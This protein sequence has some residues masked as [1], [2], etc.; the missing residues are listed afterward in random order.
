[1]S[2]IQGD[3]YWAI[4]EKNIDNFWTV[5]AIQL[6]LDGWMQGMLKLVFSMHTVF[7][8]VE[9][10]EIQR[11]WAYIAIVKAYYWGNSNPIATQR[12]LPNLYKLMTTHSKSHNI[13][14]FDSIV[15]ENW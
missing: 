12:K 7:V 2:V 9:H 11:F 8:V 5:G 15:W 4:W 13:Q 1:M 10:V 3:N 6:K 14:K